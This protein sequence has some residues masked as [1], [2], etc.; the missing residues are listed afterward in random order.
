MGAKQA[1]VIEASDI[2][3]CRD[4]RKACE[5][6]SCGRYGRCWTCPPYVGDIDELIKTAKQY[7]YAVVYRTVSPLEDSFDIEGM[8]EAGKNHNSLSLKIS[9]CAKPLGNFLHLSAGGCRICDRCAK[10]DDLPC[11]FP[12]KALC[13]LEAYG[14]DVSALAKTAGMPYIAGVNTVSYFGAVLFNKE[15]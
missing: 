12:Q 1:K 3:F 9:E 10:E 14:V 8:L 11:R 2:S 7:K 15:G 4:F 13:S 5:A 6:N